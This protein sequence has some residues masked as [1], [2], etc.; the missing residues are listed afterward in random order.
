V[1][2]RLRILESIEAGEIS[3]EEGARRL[4]ALARPPGASE[5]PAAPSAPVARV[6]R[7]V[8]V[9]WVWQPV[10]WSG[11]ALVAGGGLLVGAVY[12]G[13]L[14]AGWLIGGWL[15]FAVG[16]LVVL[17]GWWLQ[18]A[19][20]LYLRVRQPDGPNVFLALP[21]PL[22]PLAWVLRVVRPFVP[23]LGE[24]GVDEVLLAMREEVR[25]GRHLVVEVDEGVGREQVQVYFG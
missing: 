20:W 9:R 10:F 17:L 13:A 22:G 1:E 18:R 7:P 11:V 19:H 5:P 4:G 3:V 2:E 14:A 15:L 25:R 24:T 21:L 12:T 8:W 16:V 23:Q 6:A